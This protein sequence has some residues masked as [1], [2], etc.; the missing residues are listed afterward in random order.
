MHGLSFKGC[1]FVLC[2]SDSSGSDQCL[3]RP[4]GIYSVMLYHIVCGVIRF[5]LNRP[6]LAKPEKVGEH[7]RER[8]QHFP[9]DFTSVRYVLG[10]H[11]YSFPRAENFKNRGTWVAQSVERQTLDFRSGHD[12]AIMISSPT[13]DSALVMEPA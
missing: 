7:N 3:H 8:I 10:E 13:V 6:A 9:S 5:S 12:L 2:Y 11:V 4:V 1:F